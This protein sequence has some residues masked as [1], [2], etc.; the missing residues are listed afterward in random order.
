MIHTTSLAESVPKSWRN[1]GGS[2][3]ELLVWPVPDSW[4]LR[5]SVA[6]IQ[7]HGPFSAY[8]G[9]ERWFAVIDGAGVTLQFAAS[10]IVMNPQSDPLH[11]D[12]AAAPACELLAGA[13]QD[14]NLMVQRD[15]GHGAMRLARVGTPW[16]SAAPFRAAYVADA[17]TLLIDDLPDMQVSEGTLVWDDDA[18]HQLWQL[19]DSERHATT[20]AWWMEMTPHADARTVPVA[21][22][23][24]GQAT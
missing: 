7:Q 14:L 8:E 4:M 2:T 22:G 3:Q 24:V 13:T 20:R 17:S 23:P 16:L 1:G 6:R 10:E 5:V 12:G 18:A 19:I 11:F 15:R 9:I 21:D